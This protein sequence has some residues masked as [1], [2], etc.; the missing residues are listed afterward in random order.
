MAGKEGG[1]RRQEEGDGRKETGGRRQE[2]GVEELVP[3]RPAADN[4]R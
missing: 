2:T 3:H 1:G 4:E